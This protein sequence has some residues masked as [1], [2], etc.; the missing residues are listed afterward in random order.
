M[1]NPNVTPDRTCTV[2]VHNVHGWELDPGMLGKAMGLCARHM[3][4]SHTIDVY[5]QERRSTGWLEWLVVAHQITGRAAHIG[6][7]QRSHGSEFEFHP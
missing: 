6:I 2:L 1:K 4:R 7:T 5:P 3:P